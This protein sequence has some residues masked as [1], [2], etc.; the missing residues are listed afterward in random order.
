MGEWMYKSTLFM[1]TALVGG[2]SG[3]LHAA[4]ALPPGKED[5]V[6][7]GYE[8]GWAIKTVSTTWRRENS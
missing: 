5:P 4:S 8:A 1:T 7:I 6:P 3:Q 2:I